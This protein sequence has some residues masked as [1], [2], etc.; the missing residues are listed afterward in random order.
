MNNEDSKIESAVETAGLVCDIDTGV[1]LPAG[2]A[3]ASD[4]D[5]RPGKFLL[6]FPAKPAADAAK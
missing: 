5:Q 1:C 3:A 4:A 2:E 6:P